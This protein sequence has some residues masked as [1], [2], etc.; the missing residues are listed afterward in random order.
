MLRMHLELRG[1]LY[2]CGLRTASYLNRNGPS[3]AITFGARLISKTFGAWNGVP[4]APR[5]RIPNSV[6]HKLVVANQK[7]GVAK[8]TTVL[9]LAHFF[10]HRG[11]RV[12]IIDTDPQGSITSSLGLHP[13]HDLYDFIVRQFAFELCKITAG[14]RIDVL[15]SSKET[16]KVDLLLGAQ[17]SNLFTFRSMFSP[18]ERDY[19]LL[20]F[21]CAPSISVVQ[22]AA[23][24]YAEQLLIPVS[25]EVLA[26]QGALSCL[27][28]AQNM[29]EIYKGVNIRTAALLPVKVDRRLQATKLTFEWL[30]KWESKYQTPVLPGIRTDEAVQRASRH[31]QMLADYDSRCKALE[32]YT[33]AAQRLAEIMNVQLVEPAHSTDISDAETTTQEATA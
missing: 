33:I 12:L 32:D 28:T 22:S 29:N 18:I 13:E 10:A 15:G 1:A 31:R 11:L 23:L 3:P 25:M 24:I 26:M 21:D 20:L 9:A 17:G 27:E 6:S 8:T 30:T 7:G 19:D 2:N 16:T 5:R 14:E 4:E